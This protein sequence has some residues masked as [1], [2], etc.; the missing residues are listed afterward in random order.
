MP[1]EAET[2]RTSTIPIL[3]AQKALSLLARRTI[4]YP[5]TD[6]GLAGT[7]YF[8]VMADSGVTLPNHRQDF[9]AWPLQEVDGRALN[10]QWR[11]I[12]E[13][14]FFTEER[15]GPSPVLPVAGQLEVPTSG[16]AYFV[17]TQKWSKE[18]LGTADLAEGLRIR[19]RALP[20]GLDRSI[21]LET[22]LEPA[23]KGEGDDTIAR[24]TLPM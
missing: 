14:R 6:R 23:D 13:S 15:T 2:I 11:V 21:V 5:S 3:P 8:S 22:V 1:S 10:H 9:T 24:W 4:R 19:W 7:V 18:E 16:P 12:T 20:A 17:A